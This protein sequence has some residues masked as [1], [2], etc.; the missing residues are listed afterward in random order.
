MIEETEPGVGRF[1]ST[2]PVREEGDD[3]LVVLRLSVDWDLG[4]AVLTSIASY[5]R[6]F[7]RT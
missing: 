5:Y 4:P 1:V 6:H 2:K 3:L 7:R